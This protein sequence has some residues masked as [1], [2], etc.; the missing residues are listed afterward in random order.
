MTF[1]QVILIFRVPRNPPHKLSCST[2]ILDD[3]DYETGSFEGFV[4]ED[5]DYV[6][7]FLQS[8]AGPIIDDYP[9]SGGKVLGGKAC[10]H[11]A[12]EA[13]LRLHID[14]LQA[15]VRELEGAAVTRDGYVQEEIAMCLT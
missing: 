2:V 4:T 15:T 6:T 3:P 10:T 1:H 14:T 7:W 12:S 8:L 13:H 5:T 11:R 9:V